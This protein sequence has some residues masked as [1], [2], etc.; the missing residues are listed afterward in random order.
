MI[1]HIAGPTLVVNGQQRQRC[2]WCG[3]LLCDD[4]LDHVA[5]VVDGPFPGSGPACWPVGEYVAEDGAYWFVM[6]P[7][8]PD[9]LPETA[10]A[11][12]P[13][14]LTRSTAAEGW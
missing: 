11:R 4:D 6:R 3:A 12:L 10:C 13:H 7:A 9:D 5:S 1:V 2:S 8:D 14:E